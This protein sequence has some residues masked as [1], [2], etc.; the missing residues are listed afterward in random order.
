MW[1]N[2]LNPQKLIL[3]PLNFFYL[4][5]SIPKPLSYIESSKVQ[6]IHTF[7]KNN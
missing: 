1:L 4:N 7:I 6:S 2:R 3:P 5:Y